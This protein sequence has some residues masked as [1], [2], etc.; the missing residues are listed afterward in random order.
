LDY[1]NYDFPD[2]LKNMIGKIYLARCY[3]PPTGYIEHSRL[4]LMKDFLSQ[5]GCMVNSDIFVP[6]RWAAAQAGVANFGKNN[7]VYVDDVGSYVIINTIVVDSELEYDQPT[8]ENKCPPNCRLCINS[9]PTKALYEPFKL[10]PKKCI[11]FNNFVTQD[12]RGSVSSFIPDELRNLI[13]SKIHGCDV[14]QDVCPRNQ[15]KLKQ[16]KA[17]DRYLE[18]VEPDITLS[19]ILNMSDDYFEH[20]IRPIVYNYINDKRYFI[21]NAAIAIGNSRDVNYVNDLEIAID[22]PDTM[23]RE[24]VVWALGEIGGK[25]ARNILEEKLLKD[26][27]EDVR[28]AIVKALAQI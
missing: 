11:A 12:G 15:K 10:D 1:Y 26:T 28:K 5:N 21:R 24:Y 17:T 13:G 6:A 16:P 2:A 18:Q 19:A 25:N 9:C 22:N 4:Q 7:F 8:M 27:S 14:C 20:R 23:I 3:N